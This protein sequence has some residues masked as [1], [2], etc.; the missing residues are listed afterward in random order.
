MNAPDTADNLVRDIQLLQEELAS[1]GM[2][3]N[4][5]DSR[6]QQMEESIESTKDEIERKRDALRRVENNGHSRST[7]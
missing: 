3:R 7:Y 4:R 2:H 6:L 1:L 5:L